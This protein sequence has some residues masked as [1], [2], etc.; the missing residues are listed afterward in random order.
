MY[1][2]V[3]ESIWNHNIFIARYLNTLYLEAK[4]LC[5]LFFLQ[6]SLKWSPD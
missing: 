6:L 5:Q 1:Q 4:L 3:P 2:R